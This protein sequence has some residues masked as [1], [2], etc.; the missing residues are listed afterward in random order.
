M[1]RNSPWVPT[2]S[3]VKNDWVIDF[4]VEG[5]RFRRCLAIRDVNL[6]SLALD[7][8]RNIYK[9]AWRDAGSSNRE[10]KVSTFQD[11]AELYIQQGGEERFLP[12]IVKHFGPHT[13]V[14][15]ISH[16]DIARAARAIY[17]DAKPE[18]V[19]RQ[20]RVPIKAVQ[21]F[22]AGRRRERIPDTR[23]TRWLTPEEAERLLVTAADPEAIGLRDPNLETLR[24]IAFMLG[25]GAGPGETMAALGENWNPGTREWWL[26]GTKTVFRARYVLLPTRAVELI[27]TIPDSGPAFPAPDGQPYTFRKN[28][29]GQMAVAFNKVRD[30]AGF[31]TDVTPYVLRHTRHSWMYAMT[32]DWGDLLDQGGW[33]RSDT[34]NRYRKITPD[35]LGHRL[36]EHGWDFRRNPGAP[37]RFGEKVSLRFAPDSQ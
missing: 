20:L 6:R 14:D 29:G 12:K 30:A 2:W 8:A 7:K 16:L 34:A 10:N 13:R 17:P 24:K 4:R 22:A 31:G 1:G 19:R 23:R 26:E 18:T 35:D 15:E 32:K 9:E 3:E 27:G 36:L 25:S 21:N 5:K 28:R 37:V 11:A 33:N